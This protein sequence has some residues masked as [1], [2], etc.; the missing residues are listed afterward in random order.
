MILTAVIVGCAL[1]AGAVAHGQST[2]AAPARLDERWLGVHALGVNRVNDGRRNQQATLSERDG[3]LYLEG[4]ARK[5][6][7]WLKLAG[8]VVRIDARELVLQGELRG[9]PDM[10]WADEAPRERATR[11]EF[12]FRA[13]KGRAFWRLYEV[14]GVDC[15]CDDGCGNDFCYVDIDVKA[16]APP[17]APVA[18][19]V[20]Q[21]AR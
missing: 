15:V 17:R 4:E 7:Y 19:S 9:V 20:R 14:D 10:R 21:V 11:G 13:T 18:K 5:G 1:L 6:A 2:P 3:R 12:T 16:K 8:S